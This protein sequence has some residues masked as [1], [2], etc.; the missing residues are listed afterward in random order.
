M[1][2]DTASPDA[3]AQR[4]A[5]AGTSKQAATL[6]LQSAQLYYKE[7][8]L[9][10]ARQSFSAIKTE[11]LENSDLA[12]YLLLNAELA[13]ADGEYQRARASLLTIDT[14]DL[15]DPLRLDLTEARLLAAEG[16]PA[17]AARRLMSVDAPLKDA[18]ARQKVNDN[19]WKYLNQLSALEPETS[20]ASSEKI[21]QGWWSLRQAMLESFSLADQIARLDSWQKAWPN[22]PAATNPPSG[23]NAVKAHIPRPARVGLLLPLSG[24]LSRAGRAV[25]DGFIT[26]YLRFGRDAS[27]NVT[28]Y[29]TASDSV[30]NLYEQALVDGMDLLVGPLRKESVVEL[31]GLNPELP[32]LAL[33]YLATEQPAPNLLQVGLAIEDEAKSIAARLERD[34]AKRLLVLHNDE[35]W[36]IRASRTLR[37]QWQAPITEQTVMDL[38]TITESVGAGMFVAASESRR[39]ELSEVLR[40]DL[41][42]LPRARGDIDAVVAL[43]TNIEANA[44]VPALRFHFAQN[45]P[46]YASSQAVR[47]ASPRDLREL[48][49]FLISELPWFV[50]DNSTYTEMNEAFGLSADPLS[51]LYALGVDA[52]RLCDRLPLFGSGAIV[53]LLGSAGALRMEDGS[54]FQR[55]MAWGRIVDSQLAP[56][57]RTSGR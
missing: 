24:S 23:L 20:T 27:F 29:D 36:A 13:I 5:V 45:L 55:E 54:R 44:L 53:Q 7:N 57:S 19:I 3:L 40:E 26:T 22:H 37:S 14:D 41:Q 17:S 11:D 48:S 52:F 18:N 10:A 42:F 43:I 39:N 9:A 56:A 15:A 32:V 51:P 50:L 16:R 12:A 47:G 4:A 8:Q 31:N 46:V 30:S 28:L 35:S 33:N 21:E 6:Y 25:R 34:G 2:T 38:K 1:S 49:G